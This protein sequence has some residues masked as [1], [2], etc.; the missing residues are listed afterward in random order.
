MAKFPKTPAP[1]EPEPTELAEPEPVLD[2]LLATVAEAISLCRLLLPKIREEYP[3]WGIPGRLCPDVDSQ[4]LFAPI[5]I[6][7]FQEAEEILN[8][9]ETPQRWA[10]SAYISILER[11]EFPLFKWLQF[12]TDALNRPH[13]TRTELGHRADGK[14]LRTTAEARL[15]AMKAHK[16]KPQKA[17]S[18]KPKKEQ[19][20][21]D[22]GND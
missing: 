19:D 4:R 1:P 21:D 22:A 3:G 18:K 2:D 14:P 15:D 17:K 20:D 6:E 5:G 12:S 8:G 16:K 13:W 10:V 11:L 9:D 7:S